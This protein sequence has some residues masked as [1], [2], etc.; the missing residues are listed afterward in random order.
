M[1]VN[2][3]Q[4]KHTQRYCEFGIGAALA[5]AGIGSVITGAFNAREASAQRAETRSLSNTAHQREVRDLRAAGLNPIL[6]ARGSGASSPAG[7]AATM[8]DLGQASARAA[9]MHLQE[10]TARK[11]DQEVNINRPKEILAEGATYLAEQAK[12]N[13][14]RE[15]ASAKQ[16]LRWSKMSDAELTKETGIPIYKETLPEAKPTAR[17]KR[18]TRKH[19]M[20]ERLRRKRSKRGK[21]TN[22]QLSPR[23]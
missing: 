5:V 3:R 7:A 15:A 20:H 21:G 8:P 1:E 11:T 19:T 2:G 4:I 14:A 23:R 18:R 22:R 12:I 6:S 13:L 16:A 10:S 9:L 17:T